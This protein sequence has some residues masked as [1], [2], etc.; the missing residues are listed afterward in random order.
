M[1]NVKT[2]LIMKKIL[3]FCTIKVKGE[4]IVCFAKKNRVISLKISE[5]TL[6]CIGLFL[7]FVVLKE[8][9]KHNPIRWQ[10]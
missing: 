3:L 1:N 2:E 9:K 4:Q 6:A 8:N 5:I 10:I 7:I